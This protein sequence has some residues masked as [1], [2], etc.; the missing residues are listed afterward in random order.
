MVCITMAIVVR[1]D[2]NVP[3]YQDDDEICHLSG[4]AHPETRQVLV[5]SYRL[6]LMRGE[7]VGL[8]AGC[9]LERLHRTA[10]ETALP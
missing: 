3:N 4:K 1:L 9:P 6:I 5:G 8:A 2:P 10:G 7:V